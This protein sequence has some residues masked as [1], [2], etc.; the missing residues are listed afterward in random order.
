M[1]EK[2][3]GGYGRKNI[4]TEKKREWM[5]N[6]CGRKSEMRSYPTSKTTVYW[7]GQNQCGRSTRI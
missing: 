2:K 5:P 1:V 4:L 7:V 3:K 6:D